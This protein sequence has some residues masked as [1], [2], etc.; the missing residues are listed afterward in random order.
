MRCPA[1]GEDRHP[2][3]SMSADRG[4]IEQCSACGAPIRELG[5]LAARVALPEPGE[6]LDLSPVAIAA[7]P[8]RG[9]QT[10]AP[11][12]SD[13]P[14]NMLRLARERRTYLLREIKRLR[15]LES[16]LAQLNRLLDA[17]KG[18]QPATVVPI[19]RTGTK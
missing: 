12:K 17:A 4:V 14:P 13:E 7:A 11:A 1:C 8:A 6:P 5:P 18:R 9:K 16:E 3:V 19:N 10:A 15:R 2:S